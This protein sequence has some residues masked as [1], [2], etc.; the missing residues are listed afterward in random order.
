[1]PSIFPLF[2]RSAVAGS[3]SRQAARSFSRVAPKAS[4]PR[5]ASRAW[6]IGGGVASLVA[7]SA[8]A[9]LKDTPLL[10]TLSLETAVDPSGRTDPSS[11]LFF[12]LSLSPLSF[13]PTGPPLSIVGLGV[14]VVSFLRIQVY[15]VGFYTN[16]RMLGGVKGTEESMTAFLHGPTPCVLRIV[17]TRNTGFD[18]LRDGFV[19]SMQARLKLLSKQGKLSDDENEVRLNSTPS[20]FSCPSSPI[21]TLF[22]SL[23]SQR[24]ALAITSFKSIF[25]A[26]STATRGQELLLVKLPNN[27][28]LAVEFEG[29]VL[30]KVEGLEGGV[31]AREMM[32]GYFVEKNPNSPK[33]SF[34]LVS[35]EEEWEVE[36]TTDGRV[37]FES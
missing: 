27:G 13:P 26:A 30:G 32:V 36:R 4:I 6:F 31:L 23:P 19:R 14:R 25:N 34:F 17:P 20:S 33:V 8:F 10:P 35:N 18:H 28:G 15:S 7:I 3:S 12:P 24:L 21:L 11:N 2:L 9:L 37:G 22:L 5:A 29:E 1:M 16:C